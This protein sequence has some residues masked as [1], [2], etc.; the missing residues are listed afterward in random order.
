MKLGLLGRGIAH[1]Q[2]PQIYKSL[3]GQDFQYEL[4]DIPC[5]SSVPSFDY[6]SKNF[7]GLNIT[8]PYKNL[9]MFF[10]QSTSSNTEE[11]EALRAVNCIKFIDN[12]SYGTNTDL[13][14]FRELF[15]KYFYGASF[16][17]HFDQVIVL[18]NGSMARMISFVLNEMKIPYIKLFRSEN[19][20]LS[21]K[22]STF[23]SGLKQHHC[24]TKKKLMINAASRDFYFDQVIS[25]Q[26]IYYWDMNYNLSHQKTFF[27]SINFHNYMDGRELLQ[28]QAEYA[29]KF[30]Q[31]T[32]SIL[33]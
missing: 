27:Q 25:D 4:V 33:D 14:A 9:E 23:L 11:C 32:P 16:C 18:G 31:T 19:Q 7:D 8:A 3:I 6:F 26:H 17:D 21:E 12:V 2:S 30:F 5:S 29:V 10:H 22:L 1:S 28:L 20:S 15:K 24:V 13:L